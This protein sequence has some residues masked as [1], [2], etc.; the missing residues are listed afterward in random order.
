MGDIISSHRHRSRPFNCNLCLYQGQSSLLIGR[1]S[2]S[3]KPRHITSPCPNV[4]FAW[5]DYKS[6]CFNVIIE[7]RIYCFVVVVVWVGGWM[8]GLAGANELNKRGFQF[9]DMKCNSLRPKWP[10]ERNFQKLRHRNLLQFFSFVSLFHMSWYT[11]EMMIK[12]K[13]MMMLLN[14]NKTKGQLKF[15]AST[16]YW[17]LRLSRMHLAEADGVDGKL[18]RMVQWLSTST[19]MDKQWCKIIVMICSWWWLVG[20]VWWLA[21]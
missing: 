10:I 20:F 6:S 19:L 11:F 5:C 2:P 13:K 4:V 8:G 3:P 1:S 9:S 18:V 12:M 7:K 14:A 21:D 17:W 15:E 16:C